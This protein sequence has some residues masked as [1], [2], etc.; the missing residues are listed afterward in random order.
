MTE[1]A[2]GERAPIWHG[3]GIDIA[4]LN[5]L[6]E[7]TAVA[8][9][10]I[11]ML[12]AGDDYLQGSMPVDTRTVQIHGLLHGGASVLFAETLG[13]AAANHVVNQDTHYCVGTSISANHL[14]GA[15]AGPKTEPNSAKAVG[16]SLAPGLE[17]IG[18]ARAELLGRQTQ[19][20]NIEISQGEVLICVARLGVQVLAKRGG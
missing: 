11:V 18:V 1:A 7:H 5:E 13:S 8:R 6:H 15:K 17:V 10:G 12:E 16:E 14:R 19:V 4:G 3:S 2:S 9:L 20:W